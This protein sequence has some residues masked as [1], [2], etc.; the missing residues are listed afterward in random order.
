[1]KAFT[2]LME[3]ARSRSAPFPPKRIV[4]H[5]LA[6]SASRDFELRREALEALLRRVASARSDGLTVADVRQAPH[7]LGLFRLRREDETLPYTVLVRSIEPLVASC[8][9]PDYVRNS[10]GACKHVFSV[11]A[12]LGSGQ[13][14]VPQGS[15]PAGLRALPYLGWNPVRPVEGAGD[16][17][18][19]LT[20]NR[21][22]NIHRGFSVIHAR[23]ERYFDRDGTSPRPLKS[24]FAD[25]RKRRHALVTHLLKVLRPPGRLEASIGSDP[26]V[27][28]LLDAERERLARE[29]DQE[30]VLRGFSE[31]EGTLKQKLFP[32]QRE[33]LARFLQAGRLLLADDM[34]LGKTAQAIAACHVLFSA[35]AVRRGLLIVPASLKPQW[36]REWHA[37]TDAPLTVVDGAPDERAATLDGVR[38]GFVL[39]NYEQVLK[40]LPRLLEL[41]PQLVVLDEAQRIKNWS[42]KTALYVKKLE[43]RF[44]LVLTGTPMENRLEELSSLV[45]WV[46]PFAME[47]KW[48]LGVA[49]AVRADGSAEVVGAKNLDT[50]RARLSGCLLRRTRKEVLGQ[51][52][53]RRDTTVPVPLMP[54][55]L[56]EHEELT[57]QIAQLL[58]RGRKRPLTQ[59]EFLRLMSLL[60]QQRIICN[61]LA[62]RRF[63]D[64]WPALQQAKKPTEVLLRG[65]ASPKLLEL[66]ELLSNVVVTQERK[67]VVFSQWRRMLRL[68]QWAVSDVLDAAGV[69]SV[70]FTGE[71]SQ[72]R[73]TENL[74]DFHDDPSTRVLFASDAGGVGLNLQRAASCCINLEVPWNPAVLEQRIG[75]VHR[76]GQTQAV[77]V[78]HLTSAQGLESRIAGLV[79]S[80]KALFD[81]LFEGD[82]DAVA[83]E[84]SGSF[85]SR[86]SQLLEV[87][88]APEVPAPLEASEDV[89]VL[90]VEDELDDRL[91]DAPPPELPLAAEPSAGPRPEAKAAPFVER[92][93][94]VGPGASMGGAELVRS[95]MEGVR[96]YPGDGGKLVI[97]AQP[98]S[99]ATLGALFEGM[100]RLLGQ[101]APA[102]R[103]P[104]TEQ[105]AMAPTR[106]DVPRA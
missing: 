76:L 66:R 43:P 25:N 42:T 12:A 73:R 50:L 62:Q 34:G 13:T 72:R 88:P 74:V 18:E 89:P 41:D 71:E 48:R 94:P 51:L 36:Q 83:F 40:D 80:K 105:P 29:L 44:R 56:L 54:E 55:Q 35:K 61:G 104:S 60:T 84:R 81:G 103:P 87:P 8:D 5:A 7:A 67:V 20:W 90:Q 14:R 82:H 31:H 30:Q 58:S 15:A 96:L 21:P 99:A 93:G 39:V 10:L 95:L 9:C 1:V 79:E 70:F 11:L 101:A 78:Y 26:A 100:A 4:E 23:A 24:A 17:L 6:I 38:R 46:D 75:R 49:H 98:E 37:F 86:A 28:A 65:L 68:A 22:K 57:P 3:I 63:A 106:A 27:A 59:A 77:E 85:L 97:E 45:E 16:F 52:P 19:R 53:S 33:G 64:T 47:P 92:E 2:Q 32:Y 91:T 69:R 102:V